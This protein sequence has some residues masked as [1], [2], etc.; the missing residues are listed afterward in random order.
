LFDEIQIEKRPKGEPLTLSCNVDLGDPQD[1]LV[2]RAAALLQER[3]STRYGAHV[4][5]KKQIPVGA[6]LGGGSSDAAAVLV[7]LNYLWSL[8]FTAAELQQLGAALGADIPFFIQGGDAWVAGLGERIEPLQLASSWYVVAYPNVVIPTAEIFSDPDLTRDAEP[9]TIARFLGSG[10][11]DVWRNDLEAVAVRRYP[12]VGQL[13]NWLSRHGTAKMSGSGSAV[14][15]EV[16]SEGQAQAVVA[17]MPT[18]WQGFK[19]AAGGIKSLQRQIS[20][21]DKEN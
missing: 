6:G 17:E 9:S 10:P 2:L 16:A 13:K 7:G 14:F 11:A 1:N 12:E 20:E 15:L 4:I 21:L 18:P 3:S 5:L 19:V 8:N